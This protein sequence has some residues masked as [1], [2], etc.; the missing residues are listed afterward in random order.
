MA[1]A[2]EP[3]ST[4]AP[5]KSPS[6][7]ALANHLVCAYSPRWLSG[8]T[9]AFE[10]LVATWSPTEEPEP[11]IQPGKTLDVLRLL[12]EPGGQAVQP[13][14]PARAHTPRARRAA[15]ARDARSFPRP[16]PQRGVSDRHVGAGLR[17][18]SPDR[19]RVLPARVPARAGRIGRNGT[20]A[21][22]THASSPTKAK[23]TTSCLPRR[24]VAMRC[25]SSGR[26]ASARISS[27]TPGRA[28]FR[29]LSGHSTPLSTSPH[30][31]VRHDRPN[32]EHRA[33]CRSLEGTRPI[34]AVRVCSGT[35]SAWRI[36]HRSA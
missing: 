3:P 7:G 12:V 2:P 13:I 14:P 1:S 21:S 36:A 5:S 10:G 32:E 6:T 34:G 9:P 18:A 33:S 20:K 31:T 30:R 29:L 24:A 4:P 26:R 8:P 19:P 35:R 16:R 27:R 25:S 23:R 28:A 17:V 15:R 22:A 11:A